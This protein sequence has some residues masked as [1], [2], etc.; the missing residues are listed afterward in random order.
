MKTSSF[1]GR[2]RQALLPLLL[3]AFLLPA[4]KAQENAL[5]LISYNIRMSG[6]NPQSD[7][8]N[9]WENRKAATLEMVRQEQPTVM[10]LQEALPNQ[11]AYLDSHLN[12]YRRIGVGRDDGA[13]QG[14]MMALYYQYEQLELL[15][16]GT[17]WLSPTPDSVSFGWDAACRRTCTWARFR[18]KDSGKEF[19]CF[20]THLDHMGEVARKESILLLVQKIQSLVP[21]HLPVFLTADFNSRT[22]NPIFEPLA[23]LLTDARSAAPQTDARAT[24]NGWGKA[25]ENSV[26]DHIFLRGATPLQFSV[27]RDINYG[28]PY[29]SDHY[30]IKLQAR[31]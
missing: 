30:P 4:C 9:C 22:E 20:N 18:W 16:H 14:E 6:S 7:G 24:F 29:I 21:A 17:F 11:I 12:A 25:S 15:A 28:A 8:P 10:G 5:T 27:L 13:S 2:S 23:A 31:W 26:I 19:A 1:S 3:I